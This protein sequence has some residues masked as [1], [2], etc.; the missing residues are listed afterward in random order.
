MLLS[1][2]AIVFY[3]ALALEF[4]IRVMLRKPIYPQA[5]ETSAGTIEMTPAEAGKDEPVDP[6]QEQAQFKS[7]VKIKFVILGLGFSTLCIFIR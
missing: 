4:L 5:P 2:V 1:K 7:W 6:S 3:T